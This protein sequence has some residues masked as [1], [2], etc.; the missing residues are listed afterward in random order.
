MSA[1]S[2]TACAP[3]KV[4]LYFAVGDVQP[5][6]YH[7]VASLYAAVSLYEEVTVA[8]SDE[9]GF[10]VS[11]E[12]PEESV[13]AQMERAGDF[14]RSSIPLDARNLAVK[15]VQAVLD[16]QGIELGE[17]GLSIHIVKNVPV[18]GG[19]AGGSADAA[20]A[21]KATNRC[22]VEAGW[23]SKALTDDELRDLGAE[24][25]ADVPFCLM[26]GLAIGYGTGTELTPL[27]VPADT[28]PLHLTMILSTQGLST[29]AVF[30]ELDAGRAEG[31]YPAPGELEVPQA[32]IEA[33]IDSSPSKD[34][35]AITR[36]IRNDLQAPAITLQPALA[37]VLNQQQ[38]ADAHAFVSGSGP[39]VAV[40]R[41]E[42]RYNSQ[43]PQSKKY[44]AELKILDR[45]LV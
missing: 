13:L 8:V 1:A 19:M 35:A 4:N 9:P 32:L 18:A 15:A 33:L 43:T 24:L 31:R 3:G 45:N 39:T 5:N 36:H 26:G 42:G 21:L 22:V 14:D 44:I 16:A 11:V 28:Q 41:A 23:A 10:S 25:G 7:P 17:K 30:A 20:A 40:L 27:D 34:L 12:I 2:A 29:P 6:G 37:D 38:G